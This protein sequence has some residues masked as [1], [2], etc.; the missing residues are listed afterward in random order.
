MAESEVYRQTLKLEVQNIRLYGVRVQRKFTLMRLA[1]PLLL[2][3]R[4]VGSRFFKRGRRLRRRGKW[5]LLG[6]G[7][8]AW[9]VYRNDG[10]LLK[11]LAARFLPQRGIA[12]SSE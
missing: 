12:A 4:S 5:S 1:N 7:L 3:A 9:R 2:L 11:G 6:I 8:M 10:P